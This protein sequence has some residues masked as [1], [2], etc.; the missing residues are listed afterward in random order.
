MI[1]NLLGADNLAAALAL[2]SGQD[3][4]AAGIENAI[5]QGIGR[6]AG[7]D[8]RV[9]GTDTGTGEEGDNS[10]GN[11]RQVQGDGVTLLDAHV[12]QHPGDLGH[13]AHELSI[14][15]CASFIGLVGLVNN[16]GLVGSLYGVAVDAVV[17][18]VQTALLEPGR[19][20]IGEGASVDGLE[21]AVPVKQ[22]AGHASPELGRVLDGLV[23]E[24][25]IVLQVVEVGLLGMLATKG[26]EV[27]GESRK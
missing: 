23:V 12:L 11:H 27:S 13:V 19:V 8:D 4:L 15:D 5:A 1:D 21:V 20:A 18:G 26:G 2:I 14:G 24:L 6:K 9:N 17:R 3:Y 22:L 7:E 25:I 10:F 16:G